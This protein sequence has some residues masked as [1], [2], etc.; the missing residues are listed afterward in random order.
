MDFQ[1]TDSVL[2]FIVFLFALGCVKYQLRRENEPYRHLL[3]THAST[4]I[5]YGRHE[6]KM[7]FDMNIITPSQMLW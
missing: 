4:H 3:H 6:D 1:K 7:T 5:N 2:F